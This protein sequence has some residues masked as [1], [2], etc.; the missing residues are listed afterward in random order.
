MGSYLGCGGHLKSL[1]R[2]SVGHLELDQAVSMED[3]NISHEKGNVPL[4]PL[5]QVL[6][7]IRQVSLG[8]RFLSRLRMGQQDVLFELG[9]PKNGEEMVGL[10]DWAGNLVALARWVEEEGGG[11][12]RLF[13]V[14]TSS[15]NG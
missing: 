13:R 12:W 4:V 7:H 2:L 15:G 5:N 1:R 8:S 6:G 9:S 14:F 11:R 3:L 10:S